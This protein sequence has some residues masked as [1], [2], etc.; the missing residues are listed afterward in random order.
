MSASSVR[1]LSKWLE[2][3]RT[4]MHE[5]T[6]DD[7]PLSDAGRGRS[8]RPLAANAGFDAVTRTDGLFSA[9]LLAVSAGDQLAAV[10]SVHGEVDLETAP[11]LQEVLLPAI[12][13]G[14]GPL[15]IDLSEVAFMDSSG[16]HVLVDTHR[17]LGP[18]NRR[19][20]IVCREHGQV[21]RLLALVG[22]IDA[23]TVHRS[24]ESAVAGGDERI[25]SKP[26]TDRQPFSNGRSIRS[27]APTK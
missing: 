27:R 15:V 2:Q 21:H 18:Q 5:A 1:F 14:S 26:T 12:E 9:N 17:R 23:L 7:H 4:V 10:L 24:R 19:L 25:R 22:L 3:G 8:N 13:D 6:Y 20:A 11:R 16:V